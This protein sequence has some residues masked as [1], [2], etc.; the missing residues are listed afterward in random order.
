MLRLFTEDFMC[1]QYEDEMLQ[2]LAISALPSHITE[3]L[4]SVPLDRDHLAKELLAWFK[5]DFFSWV[6]CFCFTVYS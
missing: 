6:R 4:D 3:L 1:Q 2:A 5:N